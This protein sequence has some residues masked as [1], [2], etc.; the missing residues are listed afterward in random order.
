[1][2]LYHYFLSTSQRSLQRLWLLQKLYAMQKDPHALVINYHNNV[3][4]FERCDKN[5]S[6]P[7][8]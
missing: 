6:E 2:C 1:M 5:E 4:D 8:K 3:Q 7:V